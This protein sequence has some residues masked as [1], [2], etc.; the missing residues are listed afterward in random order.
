[1]EQGK[2]SNVDP[3]QGFRLMVDML[4]EIDSPV[5][6]GNNSPAH[7]KVLIESMF[8]HS[9]E[10]AYVYCGHLSNEVWGDARIADAVSKA[11]DRNVKIVFIVQRPHEIPSDSIVKRVIDEKG[12]RMEKFGPFKN[13]DH[14]FAVFDGRR[15]RFEDDDNAKTAVACMNAPDQGKNLNGLFESMLSLVGNE[16]KAAGRVP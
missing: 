1:M 10:T 11:A 2:E 5:R 4:I 6:V 12:I 3:M 15:Y 9:K 14:H 16:R 13:D 8:R 7:A